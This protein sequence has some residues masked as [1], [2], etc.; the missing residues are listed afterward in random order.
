MHYE[1]WDTE[2][3]NMLDDFDTEAE[4]LAM[5]GALLAINEPGSAEALMLIRI[6]RPDCGAVVASGEELAVRARA[7]FERGPLPA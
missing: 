4:A 6:N 1:L 5:I 7:A 2:S 3:R